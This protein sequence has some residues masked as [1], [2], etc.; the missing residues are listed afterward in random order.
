LDVITE[1]T[2]RLAGGKAVLG[3]GTFLNSIRFKTTLAE[4]LDVAP[5]CVSVVVV[6][7]HGLTSV[8]L[9]SAVT[10]GGVS[11]ESYL[12]QLD[13]FSAQVLYLFIIR[14]QLQCASRLK[15]SFSAF[16][17]HLSYNLAYSRSSS[18]R[19][20]HKSSRWP[21]VN[22]QHQFPDG[23][24][25]VFILASLPRFRKSCIGATKMREADA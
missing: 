3:T 23:V 14:S 4:H 22:R 25:G 11:L 1:L 15:I 9:W 7:E 8:L 24:P 12:T 5:E 19:F 16:Q 6:G 10:I 18:P 20:F 21:E 17:I 13:Y 2:R